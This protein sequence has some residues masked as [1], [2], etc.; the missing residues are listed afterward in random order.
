MG[1]GGISPW[2]LLLILVIVLLLFGTKKLRGL[3]GDLG[4]ALKGF[5]KAMA[6][7]D[8]EVKKVE[9]DKHSENIED[10]V[11]KKETTEAK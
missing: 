10:T 1:L 6:D 9:A 11:E 7:D 5:K 2:S 4:G 8:N 3:G